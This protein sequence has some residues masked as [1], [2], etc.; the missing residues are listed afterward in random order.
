[1]EGF[2]IL[3]RVRVGKVFE[4]G[5]PLILPE[6]ERCQIYYVGRGGSACSRYIIPLYHRILL[7]E[8]K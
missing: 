8:K 6:Y 4:T 7:N 1:M 2:F 5:V 3:Y